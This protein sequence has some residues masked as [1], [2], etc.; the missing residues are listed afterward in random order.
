MDDISLLCLPQVPATL[1]PGEQVRCRFSRLITGNA[2]MTEESTI[3]VLGIDDDG[4]TV[5]DFDLVQ[6]DVLDVMPIST[7]VAVATPNELLETGGTISMSISIVNQGPE[8]TTLTVLSNTLVG[9][10]NG[11]GSCQLPQ[12][13]AAGGGSY[14]CTYETFVTGSAGSPPDNVVYALAVDD[15]GNAVMVL[16]EADLFLVAV[17]PDLQH[18]KTDELLID[19]F[20]DPGDEGK[21]SPGD[22]L[23]YTIEIRNEGNG[24][25]QNVILQDIPDPNTRLLTGT[26]TTSRGSVLTGNR[27]DDE[28]VTVLLGDLG[29]GATATVQFDVL[30][31]P[32]TGTTLV[33]NQASLA[34]TPLNNPG[35]TSISGSDD[36]S[37]PFLGDPTDTVVFIPPTNLE[38]TPEPAPKAHAL[39]L[40]MIQR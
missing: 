14:H 23:R 34:H 9:D 13:L 1:M 37:T 16:D 28:I 19:L 33:R 5:A 2:N 8:L 4:V 12:E 38:P 3:T 30:V 32:G 21:V 10:L 24:A 7:L 36:P 15:E 27:T 40:P 22:T 26:V 25:A 6:V 35:G 17:D 20:E 39:F 18:T 11:I 31:V 29:I